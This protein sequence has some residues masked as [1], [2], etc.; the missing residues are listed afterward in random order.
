MSAT[1]RKHVLPDPEDQPGAAADA[2]TDGAHA[3]EY[4]TRGARGH[5]ASR[6]HL[7][8]VSPL[9]PERA[10]RGM[11][12]LIVGGVLVVGMVAILVI[13]TTLAQGAFTISELQARQADLAQQAQALS[14]GVA[15]AAAPKALEKQARSLGMVPSE[16]PVFLQVPSG[17][18]LGKPKPAGGVSASLPRLLTPA[19]ATVSEAVDNG[20]ADLPTSVPVGY[21]PAAADAA[22]KQAAANEAASAGAKAAAAQGAG[23]AKS[24]AKADGKTGAKANAK[25]NGKAK[26]KHGENA[27]WE[28]S[29]VID[30]TGKVGSTDAGLSAVPVD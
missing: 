29:T 18:V 11:F 24:G 25:T 12:A 7:R 27:L 26:G 17:K 28:D 16:N 1:A 2:T 10:S 19:D 13:N 8:I 20:R 4:A 3:T 14:E 23:T 21:D 6:P 30:V 5:R 15:A 22:T 9:R